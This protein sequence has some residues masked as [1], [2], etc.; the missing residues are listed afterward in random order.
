MTESNGARLAAVLPANSQLDIRTNLA[1]ILNSY[2]Y[3]SPYAFGV[4][5]LK[6]IVR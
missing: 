4:K 3:E 5:N 6:W 1:S 2:P